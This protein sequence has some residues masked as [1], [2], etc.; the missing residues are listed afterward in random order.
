MKTPRVDDIVVVMRPRFT[1]DKQ[2]WRWIAEELD[3]S[4]DYR[5]VPRYN[6]R[7]LCL[8]IKWMRDRGMMGAVRADDMTNRL[9]ARF[10]PD[11]SRGEKGD[12]IY[13][14]R[15]GVRRPRAIAAQLMA[16]LP[17]PRRRA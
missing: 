13:F 17:A 10:A 2:A 7:G 14:W 16:I 1:N 3:R 9:Y 5:T 8:T 15:R 11:A 4:E 12:G 6:T